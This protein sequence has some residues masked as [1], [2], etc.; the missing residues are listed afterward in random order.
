MGFLGIWETFKEVLHKSR[1]FLYSLKKSETMKRW[2]IILICALVTIN[3]QAQGKFITKTGK[4]HFFSTAAL[5]DINATNKSV[6]GLLDTQ[7][8]DLQ[9]A[10]LIKGFEF[11]KALMQEHF[12]KNYMESDKYPKADFK[13]LITNNSAVNYT[14]NGTYNVT[15]KGKLT[16]HGVTKDVDIPGTITVKDGKLTTSSTFN[17]AVADYNITIPKLYKD[18]IAKSIKV[19]VECTLDPK[20]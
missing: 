20:P 13:G 2:I 17:V 8:G 16:M 6:I 18:N 1:Y 15:V 10:A 3:T 12:N 7:T 11:K 4:I 19:T 5:E 14:T 9:F